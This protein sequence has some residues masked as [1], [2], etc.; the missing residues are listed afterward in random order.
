MLNAMID[1]CSHTCGALHN[2]LPGALAGRDFPL[3][4]SPRSTNRSK[5]KNRPRGGKPPTDGP[6]VQTLSVALPIPSRCQRVLG[7]S[8][9][10]GNPWELAPSQRASLDKTRADLE[11]Y[12][13]CPHKNVFRVRD[14]IKPRRLEVGQ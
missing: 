3:S 4:D 2:W 9:L 13:F 10:V 1:T 11:E 12:E 14:L 8:A 7:S 5:I 6:M